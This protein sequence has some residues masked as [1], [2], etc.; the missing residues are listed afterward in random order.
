MQQTSRLGLV[1]TA[2][3]VIV[4]RPGETVWT[5]PGQRHWHGAAPERFMTHLAMSGVVDLA[6]GQE[7]V[8]WQEH[9]SAADY[10][11]AAERI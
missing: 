7:A 5:P 9:V 8:D 1:V 3:E 10:A 6:A 2:D 4:L 11:A